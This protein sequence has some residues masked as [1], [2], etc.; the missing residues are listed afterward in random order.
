MYTTKE[1]K[2]EPL[3]AVTTFLAPL[4]QNDLSEAE[5]KIARE[6]L[7]TE[8]EKLEEFDI[9]TDSTME[10]NNCEGKKD[11]ENDVYIPGAGRLGRLNN[12]DLRRLNKEAEF[13]TRYASL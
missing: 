12:R 1:K 3:Y 5:K 8:V 13:D 11:Q 7:K 9:T 4:Q 6:Y 2:Y 10:N